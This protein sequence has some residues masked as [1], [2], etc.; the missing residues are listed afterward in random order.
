MA[1]SDVTVTVEALVHNALRALAQ[2]VMD[3]HGLAI[4]SVRISW[5]DASTP[6]KGRSIANEISLE[7][8]QPAP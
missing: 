7:T 1:S 6:A 2:R 4:H 8:Q 5:I 3:E